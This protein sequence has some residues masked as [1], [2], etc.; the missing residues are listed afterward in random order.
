VMSAQ[1]WHW[2]DPAVGYAKA[3]QA[4]EPGGA[5]AV[6]WTHADWPSA[7]LG[8]V[9]DQAYSEAAPDFAPSAPMH[10]RTRQG[11]LVPHW[12]AEIDAAD[13]LEQ[14]E[15]RSF[16]WRQRYGAEE[17]VGLVSTHSDHIVLDPEIRA[18]LFKRIAST[19][20]AHGGVIE[21]PYVTR[22]CLA[23]AV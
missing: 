18:R 16:S 13:G 3:H 9:L 5:L 15:V 14:P 23:R 19:I 8:P 7:A 2:I 20:R 21:V 4:L 6:F 1:A 22:L 12:E 17:Y 10:P 11:D